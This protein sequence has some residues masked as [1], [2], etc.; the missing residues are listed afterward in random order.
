[1]ARGL[2]ALTVFAALVLVV[3]TAQVAAPYDFC[4]YYT[5]GLL[6]NEEGAAAAFDLDRLNR[7]HTELHP[8]SGRRVGSFYYSPLFLAPAALL[9]R[10]DFE[11]AQLL[12]QL[13]ILLAL[14][15]I[16]YCVLEPPRP[17]WLMALL[18]LA[19]V[20]GDPI[21]IQ[22][23]Y[24]NWTA[25]LVLLI[26]LALRQT[27]RGRHRSAVLF[28]ALAFHL[29]LYAGLFLVPLWFVRAGF[30]GAG[31]TGDRDR[32]M[33]RLALGAIAVF[34][35]LLALPLPWTGL[36]AP[37]AYL[38]ALAD[39][40]GG[41]ITVFYNQ[42][43]IPATLARWTHFARSPIDWVTSNRPVESPALQALVWL[44][45]VGFVF[46]VWKLRGHPK[47]AQ[48]GT[49]TNRALALTIPYLLL[50]LPKMWDHGE[51]LFLA[52]FAV[53][54]LPRRIEAFA[55]VYLILSLTYF[56]LVQHLL[57]QALGSE[58]APFQV[59]ILLLFYPLLNLLA[60]VAIL[61]GHPASSTTPDKTA[62][63][64]A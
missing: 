4:T 57:E 36:G 48:S 3:L 39:E 26:V 1:M 9:A 30:R 47:I 61:Q 58:I 14:G 17:K 35:L 62:P 23:L 29:K 52:L 53:A 49:D 18:F 56:P 63:D 43:S 45:L 21:R 7:R 13:I 2:R 64:P 60:A 42:I 27:I 10:L 28:W 19:F 46:C 20:T 41:G 25:V 24:Q 11:A 38:G 40:A 37:A 22:F 8:D 6:A 54:A 5:A 51:L 55:A 32:R 31:R 12:N 34:L 33:P 16:L 50:F 59:Q 15:G 44:S